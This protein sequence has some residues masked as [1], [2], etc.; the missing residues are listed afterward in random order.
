MVRRSVLFSPGDQPRLMRKAPGVDADVVVF[1]LEDAVA[2]NG[3]EDARRAVRDVL[4]A[5]W[6]DPEC[7]VCVRITVDEADRDLDVLTDCAGEL[8]LDTLVCPKVDDPATV[9]RRAELARSRGIDVPILALIETAAGVLAAAEIAEAEPTDGLIF[10]AEDLAA[11]LGAVR[12]DEGTEVL[13]AR[14]HVVLAAS[15]AGVDAIDTVYT[16]FEDDEGLREEAEF[17]RQL[18][19]DGKLAIHPAQVSL[20]N[21][22][23]TPTESEIEWARRVLAARDRAKK[24]GKGVFE[25]D[26]EMIDRPLVRRAERFRELATAAGVPFDA[27]P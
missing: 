1:D 22:A 10:G 20:I 5:D 4:T 18:G 12:T 11:D 27:N 14:E 26:G 19:F 15:A 3:K 7:E 24:E 9:K 25:V 23:Y 2:P 13:Y 8:R 21:D 16:N 6:F 17:A